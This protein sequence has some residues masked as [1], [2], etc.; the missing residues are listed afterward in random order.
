MLGPWTPLVALAGT[1][2]PILWVKRWITRRLQELSM[3]WVGDPDVALTLYFVILLP[4]V[5]IHELSHWT[6]AK[7]LGVRVH[8]LS[9]G[10]ERQPRRKQVSLGSVRVGKVD[11]L[12]ASLIGLAPLLVGSAAILLIGHLVFGVDDLVRALSTQGIEG[13]QASLRELIHVGDFALWLYL[14]FAISNAMLPSYSDMATIRP[15]LIFLALAAII[16]LVVVGVP[17]IPEAVVDAVNTAAGYLATAFGL[18]LAADAVF[19][20]AIGILTLLT[21][22][23]QDR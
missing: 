15:V 4:G 8:K 6:M 20:L 11:P 19:V 17:T 9:I 1:I 22:W 12:R 21:R 10:P 2:L 13:I 23:V 7:M 3:R 5:V 16:L 14:I 18:T